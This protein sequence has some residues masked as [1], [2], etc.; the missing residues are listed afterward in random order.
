MNSSLLAAQPSDAHPAAGRRAIRDWLEGVKEGYGPRFAAAFEAVGVEDVTDLEELE[1]EEVTAALDEALAACGAK[2]IQLQRIRRAV[3]EASRGGTTETRI[4]AKGISD[5]PPQTSQSAGRA[6]SIAPRAT[7]AQ[8][9]GVPDAALWNAFFDNLR[10]P[11]QPPVIPR[12]GSVSPPSPYGYATLRSGDGPRLYFVHNIEG[13]IFLAGATFATLAHL[14]GNCHCVALEYNEDARSCNRVEALASLYVRRILQDI[15]SS[16]RHCIYVVGYSFG[17]IV[18]HQ[19]ALQFQNMRTKARLILVGS[20]V[21]WPAAGMPSRMGGYPWLGGTIEAGLFVARNLGACE[22]AEQEARAL[23][24]IDADNRD[25]K[26]VHMRIYWKHAGPKDL[27]YEDF[28]H[29]VTTGARNM[30]LMFEIM[31][32]FEPSESFLG[33]TLLVLAPESTDFEVAREVNG[34]YCQH[35]HVVYASGTHYNMLQVRQA[36]MAASAILGFLQQQGET[37]ATAPP[38]TATMPTLEITSSSQ[39]LAAPPSQATV[40]MLDIPAKVLSILNE[41]VMEAVDLNSN[42]MDSG[43]DSI[44][45]SLVATQLQHEF[46]IKVT[47]GN[48]ME[49]PT[50]AD[51]VEYVR[52]AAPQAASTAAHQPPIHRKP[53][54][55]P[56]P[57]P[58]TQGLATLQKGDGPRLYVVHGIDCD[59]FSVGASYTAISPMLAPCHT[60]ALAYDEEA[61]LC[62]SLPSLAAAYNKR[63]EEDLRKRPG[64]A[65]FIM[66]YSY[67]CV[68]AHQMAVQLQARGIKVGL[69][70]VDFEVTYPPA[71]AMARV[72]GYAWLGGDIE[73]TLLICRA[74]GGLAWAEGAA[75][76][77]LE[78]PPSERSVKD[79]KRRAFEEVVSQ[80]RGFDWARFEYFCETGGRNMQQMHT[81][82]QGQWAPAAIFRGETLLV[83]APDS[84]EFHAAVD[85][86]AKYCSSMEVVYALGTHYSI[87]QAHLA[88]KAAGCILDFMRRL[89]HSV[90]EAPALPEVPGVATLSIGHGPR[91]YMVHGIDCDVFSIGA[92][93]TAISSMLGPCHAVA[94]AFDEEAYQC[95]SIPSLAALYLQRMYQDCQRN[96]GAPVFVAGYSFGCVIAHQIALQ[97]QQFGATVNLILFDFE[98]TFPPE[99]SMDR[100]GGYEWLGG[101][102]EATLLICRST[103]AERGM[104]WAAKA[105]EVLLAQPKQERDVKE[106]QRRAFEEVLSQRKGFSKEYFQ[107]FC[108]KGG[109]NM[110]RLYTI[111]GHWAPG[112]TFDGETLL[113][114]A[115]HSAEFHGAMEVNTKYCSRLELVYALGTHYTILQAALAPKAAGCV[116]NFMRRLGH[117]VPEAPTVPD[118]LGMLKL[119]AGDGPCIFVVHG[120]DGDELGAV[121]S[122]AGVAPMLT[123]CCVHAF[124]YD[125]EAY[126]CDSVAS[127]AALY[128]YRMIQTLMRDPGKVAFLAGYSFGCVI[129]HQMALQAQDAGHPI[130]L[131]L[132]DSEV[133]YP[134]ATC[135]ERVGGYPWLGGEIE[136]ALLMCRRAGSTAWASHEV[137]A[138][139]NQSSDHRDARAVQVRAREAVPS[140]KESFAMPD[141]HEVCE[142]AGRAMD[143]LHTVAGQW[144]PHGIV[145]KGTLLVQASESPEFDVAKEVNSKYCSSLDIVSVEGTHYN[146]LH[147]ERAQVV[148]GALLAFWQEADI[149]VL[150][151]GD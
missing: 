103:G 36:P 4:L 120:I 84:K 47:A 79:L 101:D 138:L 8:K 46:G 23:L 147:A 81:I 25:T 132:F 96:P 54:A 63:V 99:N 134:P 148:A 110:E 69:I 1:G 94:F 53:V 142:R 106:L 129:A 146:L 71:P 64:C 127:L 130:G 27:P 128:N 62:D 67:G 78:Q 137:Q 145:S 112:A 11:S 117:S 28:I 40:A 139:L 44:S 72:G 149:G 68:I 39:H 124:V 89:G 144:A 10:L 143:R 51:L 150:R 5:S 14:L 33:E 125:G 95:D 48:M 135:P 98:V 116:L 20:E 19:M 59:I 18:A 77:L 82:G 100:V 32:Q 87:L 104:E 9:P 30:D 13:D 118:V 86:N 6:A 57:T 55:L 2:A 45:M 76:A 21:M 24:E 122:F 108:D 52:S 111:T 92:S 66:G 50:V 119:S 43:L 61:Y 114:L 80:K 75:A 90:P 26:G 60:Q 121:S 41:Q 83:M 123:S 22:F 49:F 85:V 113:V 12:P 88:P 16:P 37:I 141:F 38:P 91:V 74:M 93:Y 140:L 34:R 107:L 29:I 35:M 42:L 102:V 126:S 31:H 15:Q 131:V 65:G 7:I 151:N 109:R 115:P 133:T 97:A 136:A 73:A 105:A 56:G 17:C 70:L 3:S 58:A